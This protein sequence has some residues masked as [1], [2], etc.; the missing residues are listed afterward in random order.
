MNIYGIGQT[1]DGALWIGGVYGLWRFDGEGGGRSSESSGGGVWT[2]VTE[3]EEFTSSFINAVHATPKGDLWVGTRNYGAFH[4][5]R[6]GRRSGEPS[7]AWAW[8]RYD[9][10]DG[11]AD[12]NV[13]SILQADDG[14]VW[15]ATSRGVSR[16]DGRTWTTHALPPDLR[17][18]L[19]QSSDGAL[20]L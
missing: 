14:S 10:R 12:N 8:M 6:E 20:W 11:L 17:G 5:D 7:G 2:Q 4:Y 15:A 16:F 3:P 13:G 19:R 1:A 18:G 9:V